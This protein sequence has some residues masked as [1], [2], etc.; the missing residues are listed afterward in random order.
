MKGRGWR[1]WSEK[2]DSAVDW[3][4]TAEEGERCCLDCSAYRDNAAPQ[5]EAN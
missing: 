1:D 4:S 5:R 3:W 2:M